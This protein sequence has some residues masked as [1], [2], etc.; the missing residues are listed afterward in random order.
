MNLFKLVNRG[1]LYLLKQDERL[2]ID[3]IRTVAFGLI[4]LLALIPMWAASQ[5]IFYFIGAMSLVILATHLFR[6]LLFPYIDLREY[7]ADALQNKNMASA[8][9]FLSVALIMAVILFSASE[10]IGFRGH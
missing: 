5:V 10:L 6:R 1:Y 3:L 2:H 7:A 4:A 8:I 9:V